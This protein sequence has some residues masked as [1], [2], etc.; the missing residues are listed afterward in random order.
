MPTIEH[1]FTKLH[2]SC[3]AF[4]ETSPTGNTETGFVRGNGAKR[5][6]VLVGNVAATQ[7][8]PGWNYGRNLSNA[9]KIFIDTGSYGSGVVAYFLFLKWLFILNLI[10]CLLLAIFVVVPQICFSEAPYSNTTD[11]ATDERVN[12]SLYCSAHYNVS[13]SYADKHLLAL[14]FLQGTTILFYGYYS[15]SKLY[16]GTWDDESYYYYLPQAYIIVTSIVLAISLASMAK[17][18]AV[19]FRVIIL[20]SEQKRSR[21]ANMILGSWDYTLNVEKMVKRKYNSLHQEIMVMG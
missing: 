6:A 4:T 19:G 17:R 9:L 12:Q 11:G 16:I 13:W 7:W 3:F 1:A 10:V 2:I 14:D 5:R 18:T 21:Y 15:D 20:E 8:H